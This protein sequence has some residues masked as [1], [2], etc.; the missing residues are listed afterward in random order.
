M[1]EVMICDKLVQCCI[2]AFMKR[3]EAVNSASSL[4]HVVEEHDAIFGLTGV[5]AVHDITAPFVPEK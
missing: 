3:G 5:P 4:R 2:Q 1:S